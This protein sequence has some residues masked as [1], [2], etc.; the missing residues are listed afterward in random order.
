MAFRTTRRQF[1]AGSATLMA[2]TAL[3]MLPSWAQSSSLRLIFWGGQ[4]RADR[5]YGVTD[6][7]AK[8]HPDVSIDGEFLGWADY[9]PKLATQTAGGNA[10]DIMQMDYRYIGE[11]ARRG[12]LAPL[13]S[14]VGSGLDISQIDEDQLRN[15]TIDGKLTGISLGVAAGATV[16]DTKAL[17]DAGIELDPMGWTYEDLKTK[18]A[19][20]KEATGGAMTL[21]PDGSG[22]ELLL[23]NWLRQQGKALYTPEGAPAFEA[24][25]ITAWFE[26]WADLRA[27]GAIVAPEEQ[28]MDTGQL[29]TA[30]LVRGKTAM[31]FTTS[32][33][34]VAYQTLV[35][36]PLGIAIF[37]ATKTGSTGGHYR[38]SSQYFSISSRSTNADSAIAFLNFFVNSPE[39][40]AILGVE[41]GVPASAAMREAVTPLLD[42]RSRLAVQYISDLGAIAGDVPPTPP[43]SAG[44]VE[45]ALKT[46]SQEVA[47]G[48]Q[49]P[50]EAGPAFYDLVV[51]TLGRAG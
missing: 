51:A 21:A 3:G 32:N 39:A 43:A 20:F 10:P 25:D 15:G 45:V 11:Y 27:A 28:A 37:P 41:R 31:N 13:D 8:E 29:E 30:P 6:L 48:A 36:N 2:T 42:E 24:A 40:V 22:I 35:P 47:F 38:N 44:E 49:S 26:L 1:L 33:Q 7:F 16:F 4:A 14:Y 46:K 19:A 9:W 5:T 23:E 18:G 50:A 34:L 12:T 17:A